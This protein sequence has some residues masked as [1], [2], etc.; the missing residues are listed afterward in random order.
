MKIVLMGPISTVGITP[1]LYESPPLDFPTGVTGAPLMATLIGALLEQG[2][3]VCAITYGGQWATQDNKPVILKGERFEF[4]CVP[5]RKH[6][7]R[8][9]NGRIGRILDLYAYERRQLG[10]LLVQ[11]QPDFIH[12]HWT[13]DFAMAAIDS[14]FPYLITAH[15]DPVA[16]MKLFRNGYRFGRYLMARSVLRRAKS[17][18]AVSEYLRGKLLHLAKAPIDVVPNPLD[19]RFLQ[20]ITQA[21]PAPSLLTEIRFVAVINGW[22]DMK[23]PEAALLAFAAIRKT[24]SNVS[25]HLFG[26]DFQ[27][28]GTAQSWAESRG[29]AEGMVFH[30]PVSHA[31]LLDE[32]KL[33]TLMLH[34][35]RLESC[36]MGIAEAMAMGL[37]V[38]GGKNSG[39]VAW[40]IEAGGLTVDINKPEEMAEAALR[41]ISN[42]D[43]Y[44][45]CSKAAIKRVQ[46]FSPEVVINQYEALYQKSIDAFKG[47]YKEVVSEPALLRRGKAW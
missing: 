18:S 32:L 38:V 17:I 33:A 27:V 25:C 21:R 12:A 10:E 47:N 6:S 3:D 45:Q 41:L 14:K 2:H 20:T 30:G 11:I 31:Q 7:V 40:M 34:P 15:D 4:Y 42:D 19:R 22:G 5:V 23:N 28:G 39:G 46:Q 26:H 1:Y 35:S 13:Y 29:I 9:H 37:P 16:V 43:L 44:L 36:P 24:R 8:P